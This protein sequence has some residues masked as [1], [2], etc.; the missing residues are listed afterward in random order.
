MKPR[1]FKWSV[2][3]FLTTTSH[4]LQGQ[5]I[6][7]VDEAFVRANTQFS[8]SSEVIGRK[9]DERIKRSALYILREFESDL[10]TLS[11][12]P[13]MDSAEVT[14]MIHNR[15][16]DEKRKIFY[17]STAVIEDDLWHTAA[18]AGKKA[19]EKQVSR[20]L[21]DFDI[22][23]K[24][25][26]S[27]TIVFS[28]LQSSHLKKGD[29]LYI[30]VFYDCL[31]TGRSR[32]SDSSYVASKRVAELRV[33]KSENK[34]RTWIINIHFFNPD[35]SINRNKNDIEIVSSPD[36]TANVF[37]DSVAKAI[38]VL[39]SDSSALT[40]P[41]E[42]ERILK[43][44]EAR[45]EES[46]YKNLV[47][48]ADGSYNKNDFPA[49][50]QKY[51][52]ALKIKPGEDYPKT[53]SAF[54]KKKFDDSNMSQE[55]KF[56]QLVQKAKVAE[57]K[58]K[59]DE[60]REYYN[61]ALNI[62]PDEELN[63][64]I[65]VVTEIITT[66]VQIDTRINSGDYKG[67]L[68]ILTGKA[69][70]KNPEYF[71][72]TG[73]CYEKLNDGKQAAKAYT[74]AISLDP[75]FSEAYKKRAGIAEQNNNYQEALVDY[76]VCATIDKN[77][78]DALVKISDLHRTT[79][80]L[81]GAK[82]ALNKALLIDSTKSF[83]YQ[84]KGE[85]LYQEKNPFA[86][87]ENFSKAVQKDS[88]SATGYFFKGLC[89]A[90]L[91]KFTSA[92][93][94]F[95]KAIKLGLDSFSQK[96][97]HTIGED[98]YQKA[99]THFTNNKT[100]SALSWLDNALLIDPDNDEYY[101]TK[102][103]CYLRLKDFDQAI[104]N[105]TA[106]ITID[107]VNYKA[108]KQR[109]IAKFNLSR[110]KESI[111]DLETA[112]KA[113]NKAPQIYKL[114]GDS[115]FMQYEYSNA[116]QKYDTAQWIA[117]TSKMVIDEITLADLLNNRGECYF[118]LAD[119]TK[120]LEDFKNA[121]RS[122]KNEAGLYFNR[123]KTFIKLNQLNEAEEDINKALSYQP[124]NAFWNYILGQVYQQKGQYQKAI[125]L[126]SH[127][128]AMDTAHAI[129]IMPVYSRAKCF[130]SMKLFSDALND[131]LFIRKNGSNKMY[132]HFDAE[133][134]DI[135]LELNHT[136]DAIT[137]FN[138]TLAQ[139]ATDADAVYGMAVALVQKQQ[140]DQALAW[141]EKALATGKIKRD[142]IRDDR[143][144]DEFKND[145]SFRSLMKKYF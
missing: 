92:G 111:T 25:S 84:K 65:R 72:K 70:E 37:I 129:G 29:Y 22:Y 128:A 132:A 8:K 106:A 101:F 118:R 39:Q 41:A 66:M 105:Y 86:A 100:D 95:T 93:E 91:K 14:D 31:F 138:Q 18:N 137:C 58:R 122:N 107:P 120:A 103:E 46:A 5:E 53:M 104:R 110:Y 24:K 45:R 136:D 32:F 127:A 28:N 7:K 119:Y 48:E 17:D 19:Q 87:L 35:D 102:G 47:E 135:Y 4:K 2:L 59:Y 52:Y 112:S 69:A 36:L 67:A 21:S 144:I 50:Y 80:N 49:A 71:L 74:T 125:G 81:K 34:W 43:E 64:K 1:L 76:T 99:V 6:A 98:C 117:R 140:K 115:Y 83:L 116:I 88:A 33:D 68:K 11:K 77:D 126:Y 23:Y 42:K 61:L 145:K 142:K 109:G 30:K 97:I 3:I 108:Y 90:D 131:Y 85:I 114:I 12:S 20:Y 10:N 62:K 124:Q 130:V 113:E 121:L 15:C 73:W 27:A 44:N 16:T 54:A 75:D 26:D 13:G 38:P 123:G 63:A 139:D 141:L 56:S 143:R 55:Q 133:L 79:G 78:V 9:D 40:D 57:N 89:E 60:A 51:Q 82:D 96:S 134:G 94:D